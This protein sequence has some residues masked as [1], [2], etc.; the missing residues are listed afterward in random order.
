M[1]TDKKVKV[2]KAHVLKAIL[3][4]VQEQA[5]PAVYAVDGVEVTYDDITDYVDKTLEQ[6]ADR[7]VKA[8][9]RAAEKRATGDELRAAVEQVLTE[10]YQTI[11]EIAGQIKGEDVTVA[12]ITARLT[13]LVKEGKAH[14]TDIKLN[15]ATRK[16]YAAGPAPEAEKTTED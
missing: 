1:T 14:K 6:M 4:M 11:N 2:T 12:K 10:E 9:N 16:A 13:A 5:G 7:A 15:G 3:T 8:K